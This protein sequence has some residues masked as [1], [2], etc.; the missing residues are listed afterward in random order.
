MTEFSCLEVTQYNLQD[1]RIQLLTN[2][3][4]A[5]MK[6]TVMYYLWWVGRKKKEMQNQNAQEKRWVFLF[7]LKEGI[8]YFLFI[9]FAHVL[10]FSV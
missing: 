7:D 1:G 6:A 3:P 8:Q 2:W 4:P 5:T 9:I 10:V